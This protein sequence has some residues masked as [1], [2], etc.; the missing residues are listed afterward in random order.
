MALLFFSPLV[1]NVESD[2]FGEWGIFCFGCKYYVPDRFC[3]KAG[4][5]YY[6]QVLLHKLMFSLIN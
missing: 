2:L 1:P 3:I 5:Y 4:K 6:V